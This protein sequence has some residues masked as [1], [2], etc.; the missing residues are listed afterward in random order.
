MST[1]II[2]EAGVNH[3]GD[4]DKALELVDLAAASGANAVKFQ[5]FSADRL[6]RPGAEKAAYQ[7]RA[8][9][10]GDQH[11]MLKA[12]ELS[13]DA[14]RR[15][16][17]RCRERNIEF[18]STAFDEI[19]LDMLVA[20]GI[21]RIKVPSGEITNAPFV[22]YMASL[23]LPMIISTGMATMAEVE[24]AVELVRSVHARL[25]R[26]PSDE[27]LTILHCTSN[28]P[29]EAADVNLRAMMTIA[30]VTGLPVGYSDHTLGIAVSTAAV[31]M[32]A[33]VIEKHFTLDKDLPGPD[34]MASLEP[35]E[36]KALVASIREI[37]QALGDG[38][39]K[40]T[41]SELAVRALVRRSVTT[42][43][44]LEEGAVVTPADVT[45]LRP[46][47]GIPP[48]EL[49]VVYGR[50]VKQAVAAGTTLSWSDLI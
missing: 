16:A 27:G 38:V 33:A 10:A 36:L 5:T 2:A 30:Q 13:E 32:G 14:H 3:N 35:R 6:T 19:S 44:D 39:K 42:L 24:Q 17:E 34:H 31:A 11:S 12:L 18:M 40:P 9:G 1:F 47:T 46:G 8:T 15:I 50:R 48:A 25:G 23:G 29:A 45:L 21:K 26:P 37:E 41:E 43:R 22:T 28:Y 7:Q 49:D 4:E 20:L